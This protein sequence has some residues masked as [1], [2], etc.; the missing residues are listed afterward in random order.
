MRH[1]ILH[2]ISKIQPI[3]S[4]ESEQIEFVKQW[5]SSGAD[6]FRT[7]KPKTPDP[8]LVSYFAFVDQR[9]QRLLFVDH[10]KCNLWI[11]PGGHVEP[12]EHPQ[13]TVTRE[14]LEELGSFAHFLSIDPFFLTIAKTTNPVGQHTDISFWFLL[15]KPED[16]VLT[17]CKEEFHQICW[18]SLDE[19]PYHRSDSNMK[20]FIDKL[21]QHQIIKI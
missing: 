3:D 21:I 17:Y 14:C 6:L 9:Q 5:V 20:R 4:I 12:G 15:K 19:I 11:F 18:F 10:K 7:A 16:L 13:E 1:T 2:L 8:H